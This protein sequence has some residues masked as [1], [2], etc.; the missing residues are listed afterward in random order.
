MIRNQMSLPTTFGH[1]S[2]VNLETFRKNGLGLKT[3][4]W[5]VEDF[6]VLLMR[7]NTASSIVKRI[8]N[9]PQ[10]HIAPCKVDGALTLITT[11]FVH[12]WGQISG[13]SA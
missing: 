11:F 10:V 7:T 6:G 3:P 2:Y 9:H 4:V 8:R 1:P 13:A 5:F 12:M